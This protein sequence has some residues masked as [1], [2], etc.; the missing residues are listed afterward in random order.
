MKRCLPLFAILLSVALSL[1]ASPTT[2]IWDMD[3]LRALRSQPASSEY[4]KIIRKAMNESVSGIAN[5]IA[6]VILF[7]NEWTA[8]N[9]GIVQQQSALWQHLLLYRRDITERISRI[10]DVSS[11]LKQR[12]KVQKNSEILFRFPRLFFIAHI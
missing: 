2:Y 1:A 7:S 5:S 3:E 6:P 10:I 9:L 11:M 8:V 12:Y 4:K